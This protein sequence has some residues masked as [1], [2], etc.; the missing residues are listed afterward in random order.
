[1]IVNIL[2]IKKNLCALTQKPQKKLHKFHKN[3]L[4]VE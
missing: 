2:F 4:N 3:Y 1:M